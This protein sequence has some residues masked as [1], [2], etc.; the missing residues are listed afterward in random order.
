M[1]DPPRK[2]DDAQPLSLD[3]HPGSIGVRPDCEQQ[4]S[5]SCPAKGGL[6]NESDVG[7]LAMVLHA[8]D[9]TEVFSPERV[10]KLSSKCGLIAGDLFD[11]RH[12]YDLSDPRTQAMVVKCVMTTE[13]TL[14]IGS[15]PCTAFFRIQHLNLHVHG[16]AWRLKLEKGKA[17]AVLHIEFCLKL[18]KLQRVGVPIS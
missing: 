6:Y 17:K 11:L 10:T 15:P 4:Q 12:G 2:L 9:I 13:P 7:V 1:T 16:E 18:F 3:D 14:V 8:A 5:F